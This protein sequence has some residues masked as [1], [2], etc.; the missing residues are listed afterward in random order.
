LGATPLEAY[1]TWAEGI[2]TL[3]EAKT[4]DGL[5]E[6]YALPTKAITTQNQNR[7]TL[8]RYAR[9]SVLLASPRSS[10][11]TCQRRLKVDTVFR[12]PAI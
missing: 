3:D 2:K 8:S 12:F 4:I 10:H 11:G 6:R 9:R 1:G 7:S 5:L